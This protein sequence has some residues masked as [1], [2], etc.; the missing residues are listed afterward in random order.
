MGGDW[1]LDGVRV[2]GVYVLLELVESMY[3]VRMDGGFVLYQKL[4]M[5][6]AFVLYQ[7]GESVCSIRMG[8]V[9]AL[10]V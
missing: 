8:R 2:S 1:G 10:S 5:G 4:K 7:N 9:C 6:G 3:S